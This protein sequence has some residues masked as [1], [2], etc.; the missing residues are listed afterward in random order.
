MSM[1]DLDS[2]DRAIHRIKA[3][4]HRTLRWVDDRREPIPPARSSRLLVELP[5]VAEDRS[6]LWNAVEDPRE[7]PLEQGKVENLRV[8]ARMLDGLEFEAG[9]TFSF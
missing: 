9:Q 7:W 2:I 6:G 3:N 8:A 1:Q 5:L 4:I